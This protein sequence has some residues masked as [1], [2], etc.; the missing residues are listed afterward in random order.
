LDS[1]NTLNADPYLKTILAVLL[2]SAAADVGAT[3]MSIVGV[4]EIAFKA[5]YSTQ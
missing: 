5:I 2:F 4:L 1:G 3:L